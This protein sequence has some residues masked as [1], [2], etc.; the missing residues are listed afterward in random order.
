MV[1]WEDVERD[2]DYL[3]MVENFQAESIGVDKTRVSMGE[4]EYHWQ[5]HAVPLA[6]DQ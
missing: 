1:G 4:D 6:G 5:R 2:S 3:E